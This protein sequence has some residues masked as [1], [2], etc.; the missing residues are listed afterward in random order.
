MSGTGGGKPIEEAKAEKRLVQEIEINAPAEEVWNA[1]TDPKELEKWFPLEARV[2]PP[3]G[4][5]KEDGRIYLS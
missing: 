4:E 2:T 5:G 3:T 1:L